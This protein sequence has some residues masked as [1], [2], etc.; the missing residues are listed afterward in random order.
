MT[1]AELGRHTLLALALIAVAAW[2]CG[3]V[4]RRLGQPR[5]MGEI[6]GGIALGPSLLGAV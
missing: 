6:I 5:V 3:G 1:P 4:S 2:I